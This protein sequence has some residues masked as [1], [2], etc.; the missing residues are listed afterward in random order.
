[1]EL[2]EEQ[3]EMLV[4]TLMQYG[5]KV[6]GAVVVLIIGW[7]LSKALA[8]T[9]GKICDKR[10]SLDAIVKSLFQKLTRLVV[11]A[12]T[13]IIVLN[14]FGVQTASLVAMLGAAGLAVGLA[15]QGTLSNVAAGVMILILR[16][17]TLGHAI[18]VGGNV[19]L[20]DD[21]G[22]FVTRAHEPDCPTVTIPNSQLWGAT[23]IN[24]SVTHQDMRRLN[25]TIGISYDDDMDAA[26]AVLEKIVAEDT[27]FKTDPAP[28]IAVGTLNESSVDIIVR[29]YC[30]RADWWQTKL[31]FTKK[32]KEELDK[33]GISIPFPQRDV[34]LYK[35]ES[36]EKEKSSKK[37]KS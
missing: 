4:N 36:P 22:L 25:E 32:A 13:L 37:K 19:Y 17:F 30:A 20:V 33:A 23:I 26:I 10:D 27:R 28:Q 18:N 11:M 29:A 7:W 16:P 35:T 9:V 15:L 2:T 5:L 12:I 1:M 34:H 6:V 8:A 14:Q 31:D 3:I 24:Y 21:I